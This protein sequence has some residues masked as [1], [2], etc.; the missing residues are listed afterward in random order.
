MDVKFE[1]IQLEV[2]HGSNIVVGQTHFIKTTEDLYEVMATSSPNAK[3]G[4]AFN[5]ASGPCLIR[6]DG[7]DEALEK[8]AIE[9][10]QRIGA[11]HAF[12]LLMK[13]IYPISVLNAIKFTQEICTIYAATANPLQIIVATTK[14][15]RGIVSVIDGFPP[16]GVEGEKDINDRKSLLRDVMKYKR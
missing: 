7:N 9:N 13:N 12:V 15:G 6:H 11:G 10:A 8:Q 16:K 1:V 5:E 14:Q 4:I 2:P 3:F